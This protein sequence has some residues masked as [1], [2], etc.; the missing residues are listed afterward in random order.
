MPEGFTKLNIVP[1][2]VA[3]GENRVESNFLRWNGLGGTNAMLESTIV[4]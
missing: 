3:E 4:S 2:P 1:V